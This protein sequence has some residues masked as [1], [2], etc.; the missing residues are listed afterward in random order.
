MSMRAVYWCGVAMAVLLCV[1][2][3]AWAADPEP[4]KV[5]AGQLWSARPVLPW[6]GQPVAA[7]QWAPLLD[8]KLDISR[9]G[10]AGEIRRYRIHRENVMYDR[11][12]QP[13]S[14]MV[15][16]A[17]IERTLL[18]ESQPG[19]WTE[20]I[21]WT[22]FAAAQTQ[23]PEAMPVPAEVPGAA[24][25]SYEFDPKAFDYVNIPADYS[26]IQDPM[27]GYLMKVLGMD[28]TGFDALLHVLRR[29]FGDTVQIGDTKLEPRWQEGLD[30]TD[31]AAQKTVTSYQ[32]S[33]M[34]VSAA[35]V[36]R[37]SGEPCLLIWFAAEGNDV[38]SDLGA[39]PVTMRFH[40]TEHFWGELAVSL[41]DGRVVGGELRGPIPWRMEMGMNG[42]P[43][44]EMPVYGVVQQVSVWEVP[45]TAAGGSWK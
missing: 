25:L 40:G 30:I 11:V 29:S 2:G 36:T 26:R 5:P 19:W 7:G 1:T 18:R 32:L 45:A 4:A 8:A 16:E 28:L 33:D 44:A 20:R 9:R 12:G 43:P 15:A 13:A 22:Q 27:G 23:G 35:G 34:V 3:A 10:K 39:G 21:T 42:Q 17:T 38:K 31:A 14:R 24:G 37:R 41:N 6:D